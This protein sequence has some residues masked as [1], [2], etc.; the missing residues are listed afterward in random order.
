MKLN[1]SPLKFK[2]PSI[3]QFREVIK[4]YHKLGISGEVTLVGHPKIH[5][6]NGNILF[7]EEGY[8]VHGKESVLN[9]TVNAQG[10]YQWATGNT[11]HLEKLRDKLLENYPD[12]AYPF[13][14]SGEWAGGG[15]QK[16]ASTNG[17]KEFFCIIEV[18]NLR[19]EED[20]GVVDY[21]LQFMGLRNGAYSGMRDG[22]YSVPEI[23]LYD[24]RMFDQYQIKIDLSHPEDF[25]N[26]LAE[27]TLEIEK[28]CPVS[29]ELGKRSGAGEGIV[30]H[31]LTNPDRHLYFKVKGVKHSSSK[32][33]V[34][35]QVSPEKIESM[36]AFVDY[37]CTENR[38]EQAVKE[39]GGLSKENRNAFLKWMHLDIRKEEQDTLDANGFEYKD[40]Q[41]RIGEKMLGWYKSQLTK[42][43]GED[44]TE[45]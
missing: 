45:V 18:S 2:F 12:L 13:V 44:G 17:L 39:T 41:Q 28:D 35:A 1:L 5:G 43:G 25:I 29:R 8:S 11:T 4:E 23:G 22:L 24:V 31:C 21:R 7:T 32:V 37:A 42:Q 34:L 10:F 36:L 6:V 38:M 14:V 9:E 3:R 26:T 19:L 40:V 30:W 20:N 27:K 16:K 15:I 33:R